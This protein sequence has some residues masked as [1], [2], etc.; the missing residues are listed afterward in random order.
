MTQSAVH[1]SSNVQRGVALM[2][3]LKRC[4]GKF[5]FGGGDVV[6]LKVEVG[7]R[8]ASTIERQLELWG[9]SQ[10]CVSFEITGNK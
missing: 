2:R 9:T 6:R 7:Q 1:T 10:S 3:D 8:P 5:G 4:L